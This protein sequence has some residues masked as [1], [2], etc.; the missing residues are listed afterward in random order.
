MQGHWEICWI[1]TISELYLSRR[2][3]MLEMS[4]TRMPQK[5]LSADKML[6]PYSLLLK[7][8]H[9]AP[10]TPGFVLCLCLGT[11]RNPLLP[12]PAAWWFKCSTF[13]GESNWPNMS[14][15][16]QLPRPFGETLEICDSWIWQ[17]ESFKQFPQQTIVSY[18][19]W[20]LMHWLYL[21]VRL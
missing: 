10:G 12:L 15:N 17:F 16:L 18:E 2:Q 4:R 19:F 9:C 20:A 3:D 11:L 14:K 13:S 6:L 1:S 8:H 21:I 5:H 7:S